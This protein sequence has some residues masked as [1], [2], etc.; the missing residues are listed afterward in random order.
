MK[1]T[2]LGL[3]PIGLASQKNQGIDLSVRRPGRLDVES[4]LGRDRPVFRDP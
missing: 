4:H 2:A 3:L 1:M